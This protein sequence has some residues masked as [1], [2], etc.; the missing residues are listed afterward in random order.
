MKGV[1]GDMGHVGPARP[2]GLE[3]NRGLSGVKGDRGYPGFIGPK[4]DSGVSGPGGHNSSIGPP[5][6]KGEMGARGLKGQLGTK[7]AKGSKGF[8]SSTSISTGVAYERWGN[9]SCRS[10]AEVVYSVRT[11]STN[12]RH[13]GGG[14]NYICM[15]D[16]PQYTL[17]SMVT[18]LHGN[19]VLAK[20]SGV[21]DLIAIGK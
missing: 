13:Q 9:S 12:S 5:G 6:P 16:D 14:A 20:T 18:E 11:G 10:G 4:G 21:G 7:G 8:P 1:K 15:P 19:Q 3:G 2:N 17:P